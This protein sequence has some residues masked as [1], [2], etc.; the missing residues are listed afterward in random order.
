MAKS[1]L[2]P[3]KDKDVKTIRER[4]DYAKREW[5]DIRREGA[6]DMRYVGGQPF[7]EDDLE[8][9]ED[10]PTIAPEEMSQYR[11]Q[12]TNALRGNPRGIKYQPAGN[13]ADHKSAEFY[14][15]KAREIEYRSHAVEAYIGAAENVLQRS[16]GYFKIEKEYEG[17]RSPNQQLKISGFP[18]PDVVLLDPDAKRRTSEDMKYAFELEV[19]PKAEFKRK[20]KKAKVLNFGDYQTQYKDWLPSSKSVQVAKYWSV[21][22]YERELFAVMLSLTD[23]QTGQEQLAPKPMFVFKDEIE[24]IQRQASRGVRIRSQRSVRTVEY[25]DVM[26]RVTNGLEILHEEEWDGK[27]IPIVSIYGPILYVPDGGMT[28]KVIL[29]MTR[30]GRDPWKAY[31]Y[32]CCAQLEVLGMVPHGSVMSVEGQLDGFLDD[33]EESLHKPKLV[34]QYKDR[35]P[36]MPAEAPSLGP[37]TRLAY[38]QGEYLQAAEMVKEGFRR[39]IQAAMGSNFLP[40]QAQRINDKSGAALNKIDEAA[41]QGTYHFVDAYEDGIRHCGV[42]LEDLIDKVHDYTGETSW[43]DS[44][45]EARSVKINDPTDKDAYSTRGDHLVTVTT[46]PSSDSEF[47]AVDK[48]LEQLIGNLQMIVEVCGKDVAA[49]IFAQ[50]IRMRTMGAGG[51]AI[52]D[53]IEPQA[54]KTKDGQPPNPELLKAQGQIQQLTQQLQQAGMVI[55]TK[56]VEGQTKYSIE[57][58]KTEATSQDKDK[59]REVKLYVAELS[60]KVDRMFLLIEGLKMVNEKDGQRLEHDQARLGRAHESIENAKDRSHDIHAADRAALQAGVAAAAGAADDTT[61]A[62]RDAALTASQIDQE[63]AHAAA[64]R[65][66]EADLAPPPTA[67]A[68]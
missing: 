19:M 9:R 20:F 43:M 35:L 62:H 54:F 5:A 18:D 4:Y 46:A 17:P 50:A 11:N 26:L 3:T 29:S 66:Q 16:Y 39:A 21:E 65:Q 38:T 49:A 2:D 7:D 64:G 6:L 13:G 12:V 68:E 36:G 34:L 41:T 58:L 8:D 51:D 44:K 10:R 53:L 33:W 22:T 48:F 37:P 24:A 59:D 31:C 42:V 23:R 63:A 14:Q 67:G 15:N 60:A 57:K 47:D 1:L 56:Q 55:H 27:Y 52:A 25:P 28:K 40:T 30:F 45:L 61:A 32:A